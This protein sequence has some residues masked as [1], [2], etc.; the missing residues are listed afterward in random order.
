VISDIRMPDM[1]GLQLY[2]SLN[3]IYQNLRLIL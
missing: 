2:N 1:N 3:A